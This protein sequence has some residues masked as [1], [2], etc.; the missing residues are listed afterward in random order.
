MPN[1]ALGQNPIKSMEARLQDLKSQGVVRRASGQPGYLLAPLANR[2]R[3]EKSRLSQPAQTSIPKAPSKPE[4]APGKSNK[5]SASAGAGHR[6]RLSVAQCLAGGSK[7][8][9]LVP[10]ET[11]ER[12]DSEV[13]A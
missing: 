7:E 6:H 8:K 10:G 13:A 12:A 1:G 4:P 2:A 11:H 3:R 9:H 5:G